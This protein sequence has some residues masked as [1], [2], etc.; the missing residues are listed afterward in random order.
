[1]P[2]NKSS[3]G[4]MVYVVITLIIFF[5]VIIPIPVIL[6]NYI[7]LLNIFFSVLLII[8]V[9]LTAKNNYNSFFPNIIL[10]FIILNFI[11]NFLVLRLILTLGENFY[12][13]II[14]SAASMFYN[15]NS[16][17]L[18]TGLI[19]LGILVLIHS[20]FNIKIAAR[21]RIIFLSFTPEK[22]K[23]KIKS[24]NSADNDDIAKTE[25]LFKN[26]TE[27][28]K[29]MNWV[30]KILSDYEKTRIFFILINS[31]AGF[32]SGIRLREEEAEETLV[33]YLSLA[34]TSGVLLFIPAVL[35]TAAVWFVHKKRFS[36]CP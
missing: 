11:C 5:I 19:I 36:S 18:I 25:I 16:I 13:G 28:Y 3:Y 12:S 23:E 10:F 21:I 22:L 27:Y 34:M 32:L 2:E 17:I 4:T 30:I 1:M 9:L 7:I 29:E 24:I 8:D 31:A 15:L 6:F 33:I 35:L 20:M 14:L 26:E